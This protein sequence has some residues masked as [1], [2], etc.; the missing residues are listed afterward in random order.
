MS[1]SLGDLNSRTGHLSE[2]LYEDDQHSEGF[3]DNDLFDSDEVG[4]LIGERA[5][6]DNNTNNLGFKLI[7]FCKMTGLVI[8]NGRVGDD[9]GVG[10][11]TCKDKSVVDYCILSKDLFS[12]V[13]YFSVMEFCEIYSDVHCPV[14][15]HLL[16]QNEVRAND[17]LA[18]DVKNPKNEDLLSKS[19]E[20]G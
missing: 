3:V 5:S 16:K 6:Q 7:D 10:K 15:L 4:T 8:A 17:C 11:C 14:V 2:M 18:D 20:K 1:V 13:K 19:R 12:K 9:T